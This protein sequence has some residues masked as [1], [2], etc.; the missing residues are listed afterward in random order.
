MIMKIIDSTG[1]V[2]FNFNVIAAVVAVTLQV[3][4]LLFPFMPSQ[5]SR[6]LFLLMILKK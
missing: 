4:L 1:C 6:L 3:L 2:L 5:V